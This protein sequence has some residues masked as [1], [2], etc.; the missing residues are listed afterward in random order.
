MC[1]YITADIAA[2]SCFL[3]S[4]SQLMWIETVHKWSLQSWRASFHFCTEWW[5]NHQTGDVCTT[6]TRM[7]R[8]MLLA[9]QAT[10]FRSSVVSRML[11]FF[12]M[13]VRLGIHLLQPREFLGLTQLYPYN[14]PVS[15]TVAVITF[16]SCT[17]DIYR[18]VLLVQANPR[19][20]DGVG[21]H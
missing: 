17:S 20:L 16:A 5:S 18:G 9:N 13:R 10:R 11:T 19:N 14:R 1:W 15:F 6:C 4:T 12:A 21:T 8:C 7:G 3:E 2:S